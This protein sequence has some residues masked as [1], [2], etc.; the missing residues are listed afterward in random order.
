VDR[1]VARKIGSRAA[2]ASALL[3]PLVLV[4]PVLAVVAGCDGGGPKMV[5]IAGQVIYQSQPLTSGT[6]LYIPRDRDSGRQARGEI[7]PDGTFRLM[8][9]KPGDGAMVGEYDIS[10]VALK[11]HPG[12]SREA[13]E[14]AGG[15]V[16]RGSLIPEKYGDPSKSGLSDDVTSDHPGEKRIELNDD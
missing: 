12:E 7:Q 3:V 2:R 4:A 13:I 8:T 14:A 5:P 16:P 1:N 11:A 15:I 10:I 9:F 6:V